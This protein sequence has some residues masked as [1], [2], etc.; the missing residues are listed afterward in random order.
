LPLLELNKERVVG[1]KN[2]TVNE[3][4]FDGHFPVFPS[5]KALRNNAAVTR[6]KLFKV[7][8]YWYKT[9]HRREIAMDPTQKA[10]A[11]G[12]KKFARHLL[13][14]TCLTAAAAGAAHA[15]TINETS[16]SG[17]DFSNTF[18]GANALPAGTTEVLGQLNPFSDTDFFMFS[19]LLG[20]GAYTLTGVYTGFANYG[21]LDSLGN[22]L[23]SP[24]GNPA[25]LGGTTPGNGI[26]VVEVLNSEGTPT[27][28]LTLNAA[29]AGAPEP[30]TLSAVGLGLAGAFALRRKLKK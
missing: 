4:L 14:T 8:G 3:P 15:G 23:N 17:G 6:A 29:Q 30:S 26:L 21:I 7:P 11:K 9:K 10:P 16:V 5:C 22:T 1:I 18:G 24:T 13:T 19:G 12:L 28:D 25:S 27:Y 2:F 20:G